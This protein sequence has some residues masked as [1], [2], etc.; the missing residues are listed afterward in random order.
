MSS[1]SKLWG[2]FSDDKNLRVLA[3]LGG[4]FAAIVAAIWQ[5]YL[6]FGPQPMA[7][8]RARVIAT[9]ATVDTRAL[10]RLR[11]R[12]TRALDAESEALDKI[13]RQI[14]AA[15]TPPRPKAR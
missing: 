15:N 2:W 11:E 10:D 12:E 3:F 14:E 6:H 4:S 7:S 13:S 5:L 9:A 1:A 8:P